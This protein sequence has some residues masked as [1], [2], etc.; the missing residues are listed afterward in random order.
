MKTIFGSNK[1]TALGVILL[2]L[3]VPAG[4]S[5]YDGE[6]ALLQFLYAAVPF[7]LMGL[8]AAFACAGM[9]MRKEDAD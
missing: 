8:G 1:L 9:A 2:V 5:H 4:R 3:A 6:Q 7:V